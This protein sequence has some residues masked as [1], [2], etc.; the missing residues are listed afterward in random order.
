M[1]LT[2]TR[3]MNPGRGLKDLGACEIAKTKQGIVRQDSQHPAKKSGLPRQDQN[4]LQQKAFGSPAHFNA[5][6]TFRQYMGGSSVQVENRCKRPA[7]DAHDEA[8]RQ[9]LTYGEGQG[10]IETSKSPCK[11]TKVCSSTI[12][13]AQS[14][15]EI[16]VSSAGVR[17]GGR[18][19]DETLQE[20]RSGDADKV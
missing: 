3:I 12:E 7:R 2:E 14:V 9:G 4:P 18:C 11:R 19:K 1:D 10:R 15:N 13:N 8:T 6:F 5:E 20:G 17:L 16:A